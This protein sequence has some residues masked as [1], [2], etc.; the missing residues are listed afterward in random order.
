MRVD[1]LASRWGA[2]VE[3]SELHRHLERNPA[4]VVTLTHVETSTGVTAPVADL[5]EV[6]RRSGALVVLDAV[7]SLGGMPCD[8]DERGIDVVISGA[9][10]ALGV[11]P[12]LSI[13]AASG[14]AMDRRRSLPRVPAYYAD[15][16][17]WERS[18][19][20]PQTYFS[21]HAVNL[22]YA[23]RTAMDIIVSE[24]LERRFER[25]RNLS[26]AFRSGMATLGFTSL[27]DESYLS[28]TMSVLAYPAGVEDAAFRSELSK[29]GVVTAACLGELAGRGIRFGHMGNITQVEV[30]QAIAACGATAQEMGAQVDPGAGVAAA[31]RALEAVAAH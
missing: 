26:R 13:L 27:T 19:A 1:R 23:L 11:P 18:M 4:A 29:R 8:M 14:R 24:G 6:A 30:L 22:F 2:S 9:Q 21:T 12:G 5:V 10:K 31:Q 16:L 25:H 7:S 3:P 20:E 17:N 15:L 28:P